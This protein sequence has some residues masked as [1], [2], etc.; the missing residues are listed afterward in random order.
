[1]RGVVI[2]CET[3]MMPTKQKLYSPCES[4]Y[5]DYSTNEDTL[6]C[7]RREKQERQHTRLEYADMWNLSRIPLDFCENK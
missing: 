2:P 7:M 4:I 6:I 3:S 5:E 1:M